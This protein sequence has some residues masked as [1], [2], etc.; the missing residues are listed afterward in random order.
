MLGMI[1]VLTM[2][3]FPSILVQAKVTNGLTNTA[4]TQTT[5]GFADK[6]I[7]VP[8]KGTTTTN[9]LSNGK[10]VT[11]RVGD[12]ILASVDKQG[13]IEGKSQ[14]KTQLIATCNGKEYKCLLTVYKERLSIKEEAKT[15]YH[16]DVIHVT[17]KDRKEK[18]TLLI[19]VADDTVEAKIT[20]W[21]GDEATILLTPKKIGKTSVRIK[22][23]KSVDELEVALTV[24]DELSA[25]EIYKQCTKAMVEIKIKTADGGDSL[26]SGF[27]ISENKIVTN[28][29]VIEGA[30]SVTVIDYEGKE[31]PVLYLHDYNKDFDLAILGVEADHKAAILSYLP[32]KIGDRI[33]AIGSPYGLTGTFS[34]GIISKDIRK[35]ELDIIYTQI[36]ASLSRGNSGG[37]LINRFGEVI[38][39]NTFTRSEGQN[40]NFAVPITYLLNLKQDSQ[41]DISAFFAENTAKK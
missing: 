17:L 30:V 33:Y 35:L 5:I 41:N 34:S 40:L 21:S 9:F 8:I 39:V 10:K 4:N 31:Y 1:M 22:R 19:E 36:T 16:E 11:Y 3:T 27:F 2:A 25:V 23:S 20:S 26:G 18:E 6:A 15:I 12:P 32:S 37:P 7:Q 38:G 13:N 28:Y 14:G 24:E 29:H